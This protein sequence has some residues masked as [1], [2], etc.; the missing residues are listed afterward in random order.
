MENRKPERQ[1]PMPLQVNNESSSASSPCWWWPG[2]K[3]RLKDCLLLL[4]SLVLSLL[5]GCAQRAEQSVKMPLFNQFVTENLEWHEVQR[6][7]FMPLGNQTAHAGVDEAVQSALATEFQRAGRFEVVMA[8]PA[9]DAVLAEEVFSNG[10]FDEWQLLA[11]AQQYH[12]QAV[13]LG[14][15]TQFH[16]YAPPRLGMSLMLI[17]PAQAVVIAAVDGVWDAREQATADRA[18][19]YYA[20]TVNFPETILAADL[21]LESPDVFRRFVSYS[22]AQSIARTVAARGVGLAGFPATPSRTDNAHAPPESAS[23][24]EHEFVRAP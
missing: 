13:L 2:L 12:V 14:K 9:E 4:A 1:V 18:R 15:V 20:Q 23:D 7:L 17:S 22:V 19:A 5:P 6:V 11:L 21:V 10:T 8:R 3:A 16:P 24:S